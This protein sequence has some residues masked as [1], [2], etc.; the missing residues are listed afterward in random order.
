M[1]IRDRSFPEEL[2]NAISLKQITKLNYD[3]VS[4]AKKLVISI[5]NRIA[6]LRKDP[7][8]ILNAFNQS[9]YKRNEYLVLKKGNELISTKIIGVNET[10]HLLT[11]KGSFTF[12]EVD[13]KFKQ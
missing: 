6:F 7:D 2:S 8:K 10:G 5:Q 1:C 4:I 9:L 3:P 12:G 11:D 13:F